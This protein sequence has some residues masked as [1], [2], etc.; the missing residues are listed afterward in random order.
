MQQAPSPATHK[1]AVAATLTLSWETFD[2]LSSM[3]SLAT[4]TKA[5]AAA[6][7]TKTATPRRSGDPHDGGTVHTLIYP[8]LV[9]G[10]LIPPYRNCSRL[11]YS[12]EVPVHH[13]LET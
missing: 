1:A 3:Q 5:M 7:I 8:F 6:T 13:S 4:A 12:F 10:S 11:F 2:L 9:H